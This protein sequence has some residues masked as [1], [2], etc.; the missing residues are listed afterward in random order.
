MVIVPYCLIVWPLESLSVAPDGFVFNGKP[1][2]DIHFGKICLKTLMG[3]ML[4]AVTLSTLPLSC[5]ILPG[6]GSILITANA[7]VLSMSFACESMSTTLNVSFSKSSATSAVCSTALMFLFPW[8]PDDF[9]SV[10][11]RHTFPQR[12]VRP[13]LL[14]TAFSAGHWP[15]AWERPQF[16]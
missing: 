10:G 4:P 5:V 14:Q 16:R 1:S 7:S 12:P 8:R 11:F 6:Y 3:S 9:L 13:N 2:L 15:R